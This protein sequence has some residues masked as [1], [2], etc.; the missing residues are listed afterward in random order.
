MDFDA[1]H[2]P[3]DPAKKDVIFKLSIPIEEDFQ[4]DLGEF[5]RLRR[6]GR[7]GDAD[8]HFQQCLKHLTGVPYVL[9]Q[10]C[11]MLLASGS[12][13][14]F[15]TVS[16]R[17]KYPSL[18]SEE[19]VKDPCLDML[20][21]NFWLLDLLAKV[22]QPYFDGDIF[23]AIKRILGKLETES[24][25]G[26]T[27]VH[28]VTQRVK[29]HYRKVFDWNK[30]YHR[31]LAE[32]RIWDLRDLLV[33]GGSLF[34]SQFFSQCLNASTFPKALDQLYEDWIQ[35]EY[36]ESTAL[37][38][39]DLFTSILIDSPS[40]LQDDPKPRLLLEY[41]E[42]LVESIQTHDPSNMKSRPFIQWII[43]KSISEMGDI[44]ERPDGLRLRDFSGTVIRPGRGIHLPVYIPA[45]PWDNPH[46]DMF[47]VRSS[48]QQ[49]QSLHVA[50]Q[51]ARYIGDYRLQ[52]M[53]LKLLILHTQE[54]KVLMESL[55]SLQWEQGDNEGFLETCLSKYLAVSGENGT[56]REDL[57]S[58]FKKIDNILPG[59]LTQILPVVYNSNSFC[60][61][62]ASLLWAR[63]VVKAL[64]TD[65]A[66]DEDEGNRFLQVNINFW[67]GRLTEYGSRL[68][69]YLINHIRKEF[70]AEIPP[71][72][73]GPL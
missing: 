72:I 47:S 71:Q 6:L 36:D 15:R 28:S 61:P 5:C 46:W 70:R 13:N 39:L 3:S 9:V 45:K 21:G 55:Q 51:A 57:I 1:V 7:F 53:C 52:A 27:E 31:L 14:S 32:N 68:P 56:T 64:L 4:P 10:Y 26:S 22:P 8:K 29:E 40:S 23:E 35:P 54:P 34:G 33:A 19:S 69:H 44:P 41:S 73:K 2:D 18:V 37:A 62:K 17:Y 43:A 25:M 63:D 12:Y 48:P 58:D 30:L 20:E 42:S 11:E 65:H 38:L 16:Y 50:L 59:N 49:R 24:A 66:A 67:N 60:E